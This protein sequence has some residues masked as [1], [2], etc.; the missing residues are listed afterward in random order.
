MLCPR[1]SILYSSCNLVHM[2]YAHVY[3][4]TA[5]TVKLCQEKESGTCNYKLTVERIENLAISQWL[6]VQPIRGLYNYSL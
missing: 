6:R 1:S 3:V 5:C 4:L 2:A